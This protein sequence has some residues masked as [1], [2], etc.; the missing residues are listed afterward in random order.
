[1]NRLYLR[2]LGVFGIGFV[3]MM[4][5]GAGC[6]KEALP[7]AAAEEQPA[8]FTFELTVGTSKDLPECKKGM[9]GT[10][11]FVRDP[12]SLWQCNAERWTQI[13]CLKLAAGAVA[14]SSTTKQLLACVQ[15]NWT[16]ISIGAGAPGPQGP[17][18]DP[19]ATG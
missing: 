6:A 16:P 1:M 12:A 7:T 11:A 18:G 8:V 9:S 5:M 3:A 15:G 10:T 19:G 17:K 2:F 4:V 14:Y 13:P